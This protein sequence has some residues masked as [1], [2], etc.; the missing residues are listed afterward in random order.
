VPHR[1]I[2]IEAQVAHVL[3]LIAKVDRK[4][5]KR[6]PLQNLSL[7]TGRLRLAT[8][9]GGG[10]VNVVNSEPTDLLTLAR[11]LG[12]VSTGFLRARC[13]P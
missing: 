5:R 3:D 1:G 13:S 11:E 4:L 6:N 8:G 12:L 10:V 9:S 2:T 7:I